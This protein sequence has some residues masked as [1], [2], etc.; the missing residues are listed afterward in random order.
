MEVLAPNNEKK[1][2]I[3]CVFNIFTGKSLSNQTKSTQSYFFFL[4]VTVFACEIIISEINTTPIYSVKCSQHI[5]RPS[6]ATKLNVN[7][8]TNN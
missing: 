6:E 8:K 4:E 3:Y 2:D 5:F 1:W 7:L